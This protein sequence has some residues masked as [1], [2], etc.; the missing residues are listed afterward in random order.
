MTALYTRLLKAGLWEHIRSVG[1]SWTRGVGGAHFSAHDNT[2]FLED[3]VA[4]GCFCKD[5]RA[6]GLLHPGAASV[7][8]VTAGRGLHLSLGPDNRIYA[9]IDGHSP[10]V[11]IRAGGFCRYERSRT[12]THF[13][14]EVL[15][16]V[17]HPLRG[18]AAGPARADL[19]REAREAFE[20]WE[21][22][23]ASGRLE[24]A[25]QKANRL[26]TLLVETD[27]RPLAEAVYREVVGWGLPGPS[28]V[29]AFHLGS[30]LERDGA[31]GEARA[32]FE[33]AATGADT[34][35]LP[36]AVSSLA[37]VLR[38]L[39]E[40]GRAAESYRRA[41]ATAHP[42]NAPW[43]ALELGALLE[44]LG[45]PGG[46]RDAYQTAIDSSHPE[47][48]PWAALNLALLM[49]RQGN[50]GTLA[51]YAAAIA[52]GHPDVTPWGE[53]RGGSHL[54]AL[55]RMDE[56]RAAYERAAS[57]GH[58]DAGPWA[59][60]LLGDLLAGQSD[61]SGAREA[62]VRAIDSGHPDVAPATA[63]KLGALLEEAGD[64]DGARE[65]YETAAGSDNEEAGPPAAAR[66]GAARRLNAP[67]NGS[68]GTLP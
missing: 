38:K 32:A 34:E 23:K 36:W 21:R 49:Q 48:A 46:A 27:D 22:A 62:Y 64:L 33:R 20:A 19:K 9:H 41:I 63:I 26:A 11:G 14:R 18:I 43:A 8:E 10:V 1:G 7:R 59:L 35:L 67:T 28:E 29:A 24:E 45:D 52:Y 66:L 47:F 55:G 31:L 40:H 4:S 37:G 53:L 65:A 56:S 57:S 16:L 44:D 30:L 50:P 68:A 42:E 61:A 54:R 15:P 58:P 6:G 2:A 17:L 39:G 5:T 3:L 25:A 13:K 12:L 60:S 51:A